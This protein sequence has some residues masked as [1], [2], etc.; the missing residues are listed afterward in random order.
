ML[1]KP[2]RMHVIQMCSKI[3]RLICQE[4]MKQSLAESLT[5]RREG[6][7]YIKGKSL[8]GYKGLF[9]AD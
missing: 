9:L 6:A 8:Y 7:L 5:Y 2:K 4:K 1:K 3:G